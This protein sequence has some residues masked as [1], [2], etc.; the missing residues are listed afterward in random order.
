MFLK[1]KTYFLK[2]KF[3]NKISFLLMLSCVLLIILSY[4]ISNRMINTIVKKQ[5]EEELDGTTQTLV[6]TINIAAKTSIRNHLRTI[7]DKNLEI[8]HY[9]YDQYQR[10]ILTETEAKNRAEEVL[11]SQGIGTSGYIYVVNS[12]GIIQ[13]H[14]KPEVHDDDLSDYRFIKDQMQLKSGYLEYDWKNPDDA[15]SRK[16]ALY[17]T[18]FAPWDWIISA[19]SYRDEFTE[20]INIDDFKTAF[21]NIRIKNSGYAYV[22]GPDGS[23]LIHP[24]FEND[25][26]LDAI[27][28]EGRKVI[29]EIY[30]QK[31][32]ILQ[33]TW[34]NESDNTWRE[35]TAVFKYIPDYEW[36]VA[37][38][39]YTDEAYNNLNKLKWMQV[40]IL[41]IFL[42]TMLYI[43]KKV[44]T[45]VTKPLQLLMS[46]LSNSPLSNYDIISDNPY[47]DEFGQLIKTF[48]TFIQTL[49]I[50]ISQ[51]EDALKTLSESEAR[52]RTILLTSK[53]GFI[54]VDSNQNIVM[55]NEEILSL[56]GYQSDEL[57][58]KNLYAIFD[59]SSYETLTLHLKKRQVGLRSTYE[60]LLKS[61]SGD[62]YPVLISASPLYND[63]GV[64]E[65]SF[66]MITDIRKIKETLSKLE[67][68]NKTLTELI[69]I[70]N[71][72]LD[73]TRQALVKTQIY[74]VMAETLAFIS[75]NLNT[76][77]GSSITLTSFIKDAVT[78]NDSSPCAGIV[79]PIVLLENNLNTC[80]L[81]IQDFKLLSSLNNVG[82]AIPF[83]ATMI[84]RELMKVTL[85]SINQNAKHKIESKLLC[86]HAIT[87][88]T[89]LDIFS[90]VITKLIKHIANS[91]LNQTLMPLIQMD[92]KENQHTVDI[93]FF[94]N[95]NALTTSNAN[96]VFKENFELKALNQAIEE[97]LCG[98]LSI[99]KD[100]YTFSL[101]IYSED[102]H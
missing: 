60:A 83:N 70:Q 12:K 14:P 36:I 99:Y 2:L 71:D 63:Q 4:I 94:H 38:S 51:K 29:Q 54:E 88:I 46:H 101:P 23:F 56:L 72:E 50:E 10:Q 24:S 19:S 52:I 43:I 16:K 11:L 97:V 1:L 74:E 26:M 8:V 15:T 65:G 100:H 80:N 25:N 21:N 49:Q 79:E 66:G 89:H 53:D 20:L 58:H 32:G 81:L 22:I 39:V 69:D 59:E 77:L 78:Q 73:N 62:T 57:T 41:L 68:N 84:I 48:N 96:V 64:F 45:Y 61:K 95:G 90:L 67:S 47:H 33:Y 87:L 92:I 18:Y 9:Y 34:K 76:P 98:Q 102:E 91:S 13:V 35:K 30:T 31:N 86:E 7:A 6:S 82:K 40:L 93:E 5:V 44:A 55:L 28:S 3:Q 42:L 37:T 27:N 75:H 17:M 85:S